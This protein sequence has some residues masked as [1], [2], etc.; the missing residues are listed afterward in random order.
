MAQLRNLRLQSL[1][2]EVASAALTGVPAKEIDER[3]IDPSRITDEEKAALR[4]FAWSFVSRFEL[5]RMAL[6]ELRRLGRVHDH[7]VPPAPAPDPVRVGS[8]SPG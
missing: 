1:Q 3:V 7:A 2:H 8:T 4:L 6:D 5:R